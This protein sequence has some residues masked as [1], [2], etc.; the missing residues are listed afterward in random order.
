MR[1]RA[2]DTSWAPYLQ[3]FVEVWVENSRDQVRFIA[4]GARGALRW[5]ELVTFGALES[6]GKTGDEAVEFIVPMSRRRP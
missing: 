6:K 5:R 1:A 3:S 4:H 2:G